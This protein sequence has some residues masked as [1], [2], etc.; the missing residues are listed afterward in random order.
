LTA[1]GSSRAEGEHAEFAACAGREDSERR[2][3]AK[4]DEVALRFSEQ[5]SE[6]AAMKSLLDH[7][8]L[9]V[10]PPNVS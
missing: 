3:L 6:P 2:S 8:L 4:D 9:S 5:D 10:F 1:R 7:C